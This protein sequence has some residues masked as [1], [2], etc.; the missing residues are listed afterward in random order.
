MKNILNEIVIGGTSKLI[1]A[2]GALYSIKILGAD[3]ATDLVIFSISLGV[4][5]LGYCNTINLNVV[6]PI[7]LKLINSKENYKIIKLVKF[8]IK[9]MLLTTILGVIVLYI[10]L[11]FIFN[12]IE[13]YNKIDIGAI[14]IAISLMILIC[15][16]V[17]LMIVI[18]KCFGFFY[19]SNVSL[20][21]GS[22]ASILFLYTSGQSLGAISLI[23]SI[24][25]A[26]IVQCIII[27]FITYIKFKKLFYDNVTSNNF[28]NVVIKDETVNFT[29]LSFLYIISQT[30][31]LCLGL[32]PLAML[33]NFDD[34]T[35][36]SVNY[37]RRIFDLFVSM[38]ITPAMIALSPRISEIISNKNRQE[39]G[40]LIN[41]LKALSNSILMPI[42]Y[43]VTVYSHEIS[44]EIF[45]AQNF[46]NDHISLI[47]NSICFYFSTL[48]VISNNAIFTR[49]N[50]LSCNS[51]W[52]KINIYVELFSFIMIII[53]TKIGVEL[54]GPIGVPLF[55]ALFMIIFFQ[56]LNLYLF[57][58]LYEAR[59]RFF[60]E[61]NII[62]VP[63]ISTVIFHFIFIYII[64]LFYIEKDLYTFILELIIF[65]GIKI[66]LQF[67]FHSEHYKILKDIFVKN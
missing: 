13:K 56:S 2:L 48:F 55:Y 32:F 7:I 6:S 39:I 20:L 24:I 50:I 45:T 16:I 38:L 62:L 27:S 37:A 12:N 1:S 9:K 44:L 49:I 4:A 46:N 22:L 53:A 58:K 65:L 25:L 19:F 54:Y 51:N 28:I 26:N 67:N 63:L 5:F 41:Q 57:K 33:I 31:A 17:D 8:I 36:T 47:S 43:L 59:I 66:F 14:G 11:V 23:Y 40:Y 15:F 10:L 21:I 34:G 29:K 30:P 64:E 52:A 35:L 18:L 61:I 3:S 42:V 60:N